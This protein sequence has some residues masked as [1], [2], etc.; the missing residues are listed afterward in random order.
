MKRV[1]NNLAYTVLHS[2]SY[3]NSLSN[4]RELH[5]LPKRERIRFK[6]ANL[7]YRAVRVGQPLYLAEFV[8]D[9]RFFRLL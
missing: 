6:I 2:G 9:Y 7:R 5:W 3:N 1:Q 8:A 4:F